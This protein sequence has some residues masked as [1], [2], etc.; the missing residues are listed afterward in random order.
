MK[1]WSGIE[2]SNRLA[3]IKP[4]TWQ[5]VVEDLKNDPDTEKVHTRWLAFELLILAAEY[6]QYS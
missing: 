6:K 4:E 5:E 1:T 3:A 2:I